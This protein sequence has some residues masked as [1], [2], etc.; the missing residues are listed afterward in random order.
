MSAARQ[1]AGLSRGRALAPG[2]PASIVIIARSFPSAGTPHAGAFVAE[3]AAAIARCGVSV[4][5]VNPVPA[6]RRRPKGRVAEDAWEGDG[7]G[8]MVLRPRFVSWGAKRIGPLRLARLTQAGFSAAVQRALRRHRLRPDLIYGHFLA[9]PGIAAVAAG[10]A[11]GTRAVVGVGESVDG[12]DSHLLWTL[13][14]LGLTY[15]R[16]RL[17]GAAGFIAVSRPVQR[18]LVTQLAVG[19]DR[20]LL[21]PNGVDLR[22]FHPR[23]RGQMRARLGLPGDLTLVAFVGA[24]SERK[25]VLRVLSAIRDLPGVAGVFLGSGMACPPEPAIAFWGPVPHC[26][27]AEYLAAC[28][29]F[30]LPSTAEGCSNAI[31]EALACGLPVIASRREF[32]EGVVDNEVGIL[33]EPHDVGD[34]R[35]AIV[36]L[37]E[38]A[39]LRAR[40]AAAAAARAREFDLNSRAARILEWAGQLAPGKAERHQ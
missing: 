38:D 22:V 12:D 16:P 33:I 34:L 2:M 15:A 24:F 23:D 17:A 30:A 37:H 26:R 10:R 32:N 40:Q 8:I 18:A 19:E 11:L 13:R 29:I 21:S 1:V 36:R 27:V 20:I 25:G 9:L 4:T 7:G 35:A 3:L 14:P 39:G 6:L 5:V 28:D 31:L